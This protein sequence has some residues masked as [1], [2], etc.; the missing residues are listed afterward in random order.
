MLTEFFATNVMDDD[1]RR[2]NLL[3]KEFPQHFV[4]DGQSRI[5]TKRKRGAAIG[6]LCVVTPVENE[7]YYLRVLL[8]NVCCPASFD[9]SLTIMEFW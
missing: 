1:A 5:W 2:L 7:R 3:Y 9:D 4:W 8:N 6:R